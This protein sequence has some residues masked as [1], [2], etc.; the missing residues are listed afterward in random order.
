MPSN[1]VKVTM[2]IPTVVAKDLDRLAQLNGCARTLFVNQLL[3][4][5]LT[6][7]ADR[8][9]FLA[10]LDNTIKDPDA[11]PGAQSL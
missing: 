7:Y 2:D 8:D 6:K 10:G 4:S 9:V 11:A 3:I 5:W 1:T